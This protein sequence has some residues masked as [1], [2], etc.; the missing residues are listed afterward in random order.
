MDLSSAWTLE[1]QQ[2]PGRTTKSA[3]H[4]FIQAG[5]R[6]HQELIQ[7][8]PAAADLLYLHVPLHVLTV[9]RR[10]PRQPLRPRPDHLGYR[11]AA[12][13]HVEVGGE[14]IALLG[15]RGVIVGPAVVAAAPALYVL[16]YAKRGSL[17][18]GSD[19]TAYD[20]ARRLYHDKGTLVLKKGKLH[21]L[22]NRACIAKLRPSLSHLDN[23]ASGCGRCLRPPFLTGANFFFEGRVPA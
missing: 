15:P 20:D 13:D 3:C 7:H 21:I 4:R 23:G 17:A 6:I 1:Y 16:R 14:A 22:L 12:P 2:H 8:R 9:L 19:E 18:S 11:V 5:V 10:P